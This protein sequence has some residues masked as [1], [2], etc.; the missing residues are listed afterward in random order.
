M[1]STIASNSGRSSSKKRMRSRS[2]ST[3][4]PAYTHVDPL[5]ELLESTRTH[6][7]APK[8]NNYTRSIANERYDSP[9]RCK[10]SYCINPR[11]GD[12]RM[13]DRKTSS[14]KNRNTVLLSGAI[15]ALVGSI[16]GYFIG[17]RGKRKPSK[18]AIQGAVWGGIAGAAFG[19]GWSESRTESERQQNTYKNAGAEGYSDY[20]SDYFD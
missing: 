9:R 13:C 5:D 6:I 18:A 3:A 16:I 7:Q 8:R 14:R 10:C 4:P 11:F 20:E 17:R 1:S 19:V 12:Q 2:I 15:G